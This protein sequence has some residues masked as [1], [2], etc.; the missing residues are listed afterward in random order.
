MPFD[1]WL[2]FGVEHQLCSFIL[3]YDF[4][5]LETS[6]IILQLKFRYEDP[7]PQ[8]LLIKTHF[9]N[10]GNMNNENKNWIFISKVPP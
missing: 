2:H 9:V 5:L 6:E 1:P 8:D 3:T 7:I 4:N 10:T